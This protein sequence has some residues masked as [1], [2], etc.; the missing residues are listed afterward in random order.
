MDAAYLVAR[1]HYP[2]EDSSDSIQQIKNYLSETLKKDGKDAH[3]MMSRIV[4][5]DSTYYKALYE[6]GCDFLAGEIR[7]GKSR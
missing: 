5:T 1:L 7:T 6:L 3:Q 2:G 4:K